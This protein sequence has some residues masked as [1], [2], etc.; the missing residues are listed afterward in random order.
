MEKLSLLRWVLLIVLGIWIMG[1]V[2]QFTYTLFYGGLADYEL[3]R[4]GSST[5][6]IS[7]FFSLVLFTA[8]FFAYQAI[9][10]IIK[11][12]YY[13][14]ISAKKFK[15]SGVLI[16]GTQLIS[17]LFQ[18]INSS[19][20]TLDN[21]ISFWIMDALFLLIG[22]GLLSISDLLNEGKMLKEENDLMI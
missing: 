9:K 18:F 10:E 11:S 3:F 14:S 12:G 1:L 21:T 20:K 6:V 15:T 19:T 5:F 17:I 22:I 2:A 8:V 13:N 16:V 4:F 7:L